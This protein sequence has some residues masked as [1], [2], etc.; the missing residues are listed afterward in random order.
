VFYLHTNRVIQKRID[1]SID[2]QYQI[3]KYGVSNLYPQLMEELY[4]RSPLTKAAIEVLAEFYSGQGWTNNGD[5]MINRYGQTFN[6]MLRLCSE[7]IAKFYGF[8]I[9]INY[10]GLGQGVE[11]QHIPFEYVRLA[12]PNEKQVINSVY[13]SSNWEEDSYKEKNYRGLKPV[14]YSLFNPRTAQAEVLTGRRSGQVLYFT[15]KMWSYPLATFDSIRDAVQTDSEIQTFMLAN[16]Q[17]GFHGSTIIK[18]PGGF[19]NQDE[20]DSV[21]DKIKDLVGA[22]NANSTLVAT[23]PEDFTGNLVEGIPAPNND[24]LFELTGKRIRDII[25][26]NYAIPGP[27]MGVNP[28]GGIFT[29]QAIRDSY[30][31]MNARTSNKRRLIA[32]MFKP[33]GEL[34][35]YDLGEIQE[36]AFEIPG[37][38][39]PKLN[40]DPNQLIEEKP[41]LEEETSEAKLRAL[42]G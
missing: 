21:K 31:Y 4:K 33:I 20:E 41:E 27:L 5:E 9:H 38:N 11:L 40:G 13:V 36:Q 22:G 15:P 29:Q 34:F 2:Y 18:Y 19:E 12:H 6:E 8:A 10:N 14:K 25:L 1:T 35:G 26:Q 28:E 7:D 23:T 42:Y 17:N 39:M 24:K 32:R 30:I 16:I 37:L 3:V